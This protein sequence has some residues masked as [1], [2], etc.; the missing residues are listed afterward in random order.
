LADRW[1]GPYVVTR[2]LDGGVYGLRE[3]D[4]TEAKS[5]V[6]GSRLK[7]FWNRDAENAED[8]EDVEDAAEGA[9]ADME[10]EDTANGEEVDGEPGGQEWP[11]PGRNFYVAIP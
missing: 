7:K 5:L 8:A 1:E 2:I 3:L 11:L 9:R 4:G 6:A 10:E